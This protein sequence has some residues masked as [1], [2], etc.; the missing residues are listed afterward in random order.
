MTTLSVELER[1]GDQKRLCS[2]KTERGGG[3]VQRGVGHSVSKLK[4][5]HLRVYANV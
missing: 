1:L 4:S 2:I 5:R 3:G